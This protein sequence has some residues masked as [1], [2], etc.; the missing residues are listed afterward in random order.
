M[1]IEHIVVFIFEAA[2]SPSMTMCAQE[3]GAR[4]RFADGEATQPSELVTEI[5]LDSDADVNSAPGGL[6]G[7]IAALAERQAFGGNRAPSS[8]PTTFSSPSPD[9]EV[10]HSTGEVPEQLES[11]GNEPGRQT[12]DEP[13][14]WAEDYDSTETVASTPVRDEEPEI[15]TCGRASGELAH[16]EDHGRGENSDENGTSFARLG[17]PSENTPSTNDVLLPDSF[18]E[19]VV[20]AMAL[21]IADAQASRIHQADTRSGPLPQPT[22]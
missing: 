6:A 12:Q 4:H 20:L 15:S 16:W 5:S 21:S 2:V 11:T 13:S 22:H 1:V 10:D 14:Q 3:Q 7:A 9:P 8:H 19:Q 17:V 18:E